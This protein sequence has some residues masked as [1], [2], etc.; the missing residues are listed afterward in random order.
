MVAATTKQSDK[1]IF[2]RRTAKI[3]L[4]SLLAIICLYYIFTRF[5]WAEIWRILRSADVSTFLVSSIS[6]TLLFW[7][8]R[9]LRWAYL[10]RGEKIVVSFFKLYLYTAITLGFANFTPF[11]SGEAFKVEIFRKHGG[12]RLSGYV[13]FLFEKLLDLSVITLLSLI[14]AFTLFEFRLVENLQ[15]MIIGLVIA[16]VISA[17]T[18]FFLAKRQEK[19]YSFRRE[20]LPNMRTLTV[21]V[22]LTLASWAAMILGWKYIF[23]SVNINLSMLQT[24]AVISLTTVIGIL[25]LIP[26]AVGVSEV[27][28]ATFL[29]FLGYENSIA[30]TGAV[31]IGIY[32]L[33]ILALTGI[34]LVILKGFNYSVNRAGKS[35]EN[36]KRA[37]E[38]LNL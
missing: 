9:A 37:D 27:S 25:S 3:I 2:F 11:Q 17:A 24:A 5:H 32:S 29:S 7:L 31:M 18:V 15:F 38:K 35:R 10:L 28:V 34:H 36:I 12:R 6:A 13:F 19:I 30:Q 33:V 20:A 23:Q 1:N 26:G 21:A 14:G 8:L 16:L 4:P 22:L